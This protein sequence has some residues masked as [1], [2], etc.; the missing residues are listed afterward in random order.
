M[1][2]LVRIEESVRID[3][4]RLKSPLKEAV[5]E[6]LREEYGGTY[7]K[8]LGYVVTIIDAVHIDKEGLLIPGD[9]GIKVGAAVDAL[10]FIPYQGDIVE[11]VVD[12]I[13]ESGARVKVGPMTGVLHIS[14]VF[15]G[16]YAV[17]D[18]KRGAL[19]GRGSQKIVQINDVLRVRITSISTKA[20]AKETRLMLTCRQPGLGKPEWMKQNQQKAEAAP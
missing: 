19:V 1:F 18:Q 12:E 9:G 8:E 4:L 3:P 11:G 2:Y 6:T 20:E 7:D 5:L 17:Y 16:D 13:T 15:D 10:T 14:Q